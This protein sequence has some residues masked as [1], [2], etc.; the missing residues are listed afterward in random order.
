MQQPPGSFLKQ[1]SKLT[2]IS[3]VRPGP[4]DNARIE[5]NNT[6]KDNKIEGHIQ[7]VHSRQYGSYSF[8]ASPLQQFKN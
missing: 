8:V 1:L 3:A 6:Q 5:P 7:G 2:T 4:R